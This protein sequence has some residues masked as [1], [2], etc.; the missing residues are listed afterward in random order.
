MNGKRLEFEDIP[1][2]ANAKV[3]PDLLGLQ[4][5]LE[6]AGLVAPEVGHVKPLR[7]QLEHLLGSEHVQYT[8]YIFFVERMKYCFHTFFT[9][10]H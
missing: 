9:F 4:V 2:F 5:G 6:A 8:E 10:D 1:G 7:R 3:K